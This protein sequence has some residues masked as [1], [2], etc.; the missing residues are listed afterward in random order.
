MS[1]HIWQDYDGDDDVPNLA[2]GVVVNGVAQG[3]W[4]VGRAAAL[5]AA[6][7]QHQGS[8]N[9]S[10]VQALD[11][12]GAYLLLKAKAAG[13]ELTG[14]QPAH[15][16]LIEAVAE[17]TASMSD[18]PIVP[19]KERRGVVEFVEDTGVWALE[20]LQQGAAILGF[21][22]F[23]IERF[24]RLALNPAR[25]RL[26]STV[27]HM[28]QIGL[29]AVPIIL[30]MSFLI[31]IV[32]AYQGAFQLRQFGAEI[33]VVDLLTLSVL[34]EL[35]VLL[36]AI[37][38]AGRSGSAFTAEIGSM[39]VR[40]EIDAMRTMGIEPVDVL[41]LPRLVALLIMLPILGFLADL[42]GL[43]GGALMAWNVLDI[44]PGAFIARF[45]DAATAA[46]FWTGIAK[47]PFF[48]LIIALVGCYEGL[49]VEGSAE[50]VGRQTTRSVVESI[51]LVIVADG[52]FSVF[53]AL[54]GL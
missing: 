6:L 20:N 33:F 9:L 30:L 25:F 3:G 39:K 27:H 50:S 2:D 23:V 34:R 4:T 45:Q 13:I 10:E 40:E 54:M 31:G 12:T 5:E 21:L 7:G 18:T 37:M 53:F 52:V 38:V 14:V 51:F 24:G 43:V 42:A 35:G 36:T 49:Q 41:V 16:K 22:G 15:S 19:P 11:T 47:A 8:L 17:R 46:H 44:T 32:L 1:D 26:T 29:N 48:A 28:Q